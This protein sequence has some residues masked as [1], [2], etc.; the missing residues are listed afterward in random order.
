M[1]PIL[2]ALLSSQREG[3]RALLLLLPSV[4]EDRRGDVKAGAMQ[5]LGV[6]EDAL[7]VPRTFPRREERRR[8]R[9]RV[10]ALDG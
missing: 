4:P 6:F 5:A 10:Q 8:E 3:L 7:G 2:L 9:E 1:D